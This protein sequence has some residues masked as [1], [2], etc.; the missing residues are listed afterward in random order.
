MAARPTSRQVYRREKFFRALLWAQATYTLVT[1]LWPIVDIE[2]FMAVTGPKR[3]VW[4]VKTVGALL[5]PVAVTLYSYLLIDADKRPA[6][7]LGALTAIAFTT[8]DLYYA[9]SDVIPD[10]YLADAVVEGIFL[11][12]WLYVASTSGRHDD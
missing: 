3:D 6:I 5:I 8:I 2:S 11:L 7:I 10:V 12:G 1:A 9:L 4:L